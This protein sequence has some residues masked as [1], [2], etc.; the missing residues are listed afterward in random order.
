MNLA[1]I[2]YIYSSIASSRD[3][4]WS[5]TTFAD[6]QFSYALGNNPMSCPYVV[7]SN[8]N[9][10]QNP[11]SAMASGGN[12][13]SNIDTSPPQEAYVLYGAIVGGPDQQ[14]RFFDIR[15]D[16]PETEPALDLN[17]PVLTLAA[18]HVM[19]DTQD[20]FFTQLKA[21]AFDAVKPQGTPCD[22]AF[23]C[24]TGHSLSKGAKIAI[25]VVISVV[26]LAIIGF[27][28]YWYWTHRTYQPVRKA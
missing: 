5:Y 1:M 10:P 28:G 17:A 14:D 24:K 2:M 19:N 6:S 22:E 15:T 26:G 20:P 16:W 4:A 27:C 9:S 21:G 25:G 23:P 13:I 11:H 7:G 8:P 18:L 12:D 3:K